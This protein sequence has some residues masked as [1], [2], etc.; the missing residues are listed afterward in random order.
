MPYPGP[1]SDPESVDVFLYLRP[2]S[3]GVEVES[4]VMSVIGHSGYYHSAISLV[5]LANIPGEYIIDNHI[6]ERHYELRL[7]FAVHGGA[8]FTASMRDRFS[9]YYG[10]P[11][12]ARRVI[13]A[14]EALRRLNWTPEELF[15]LWVAEADLT[16]INGQVVKRHKDV[17]I[18]N[19]DVPALLHKNTAA[20]DIAV[21]VF[22]T[23][24]GYPHFL[25][26]ASSFRET[27]VERGLLRSGMP[28]ERAV[29]LSR[30]PFEQLLDGR[31][32]LL[33]SDGQ[34]LGMKQ[35]SFAAYLSGRGM[36]S[37]AI[38]G[39]V[40]H[41]ICR[42]AGRYGTTESNLLEVCEGC[43]YED[44]WEMVDRIS[45]QMTLPGRSFFNA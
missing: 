45:V 16:R 22:R 25:G 3:N 7:Y 35:A 43:S 9:R 27:L 39:L 42:V 32:Y 28:I 31:D 37:E 13:G 44:A 11:F 23:R 1:D 6:V 33:G 15:S 4:A 2:E 40:E 10:V 19:Y 41:P 8:A 17:W 18:V 38:E 26:L 24:A 20:T 36:S 34:P 5:Y 21:M 29:H 14:F 30:S 12:D